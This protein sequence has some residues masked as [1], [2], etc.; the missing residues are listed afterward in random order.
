GEGDAHAS[1]EPG[2]NGLPGLQGQRLLVEDDGGRQ[3]LREQLLVP[4]VQE[5]PRFRLVVGARRGGD[6]RRIRAGRAGGRGRCGLQRRRLA[7]LGERAR[8]GVL[9]ICGQGESGFGEAAR[10]VVAAEADRGG[11]VRVY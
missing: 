7:S 8:L 1:I 9:R 10:V 2:E 6:A 4:F 5:A 11:E 3:V